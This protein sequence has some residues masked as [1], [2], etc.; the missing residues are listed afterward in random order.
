[1]V[2]DYCSFSMIIIKCSCIG[3]LL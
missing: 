2:D 3:P 1:M